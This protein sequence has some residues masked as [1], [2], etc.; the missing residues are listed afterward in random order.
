MTEKSYQDLVAEAK[1]RIEEVTPEQL[2]AELDAGGEVLIVDVRDRDDFEARHIPGA[3]PVPRGVL[4]VR[5]PKEIPDREESIVV[6]CG[7]G[8]RGALS[9]DT[10]RVMGYKNVRSL[11]GGFRGWESAGFETSA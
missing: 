1:T 3:V 5:L 2:K 11:Q 9:A 4:E 7:G 10:L 8:G 6:Y